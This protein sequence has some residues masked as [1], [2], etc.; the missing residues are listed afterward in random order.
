MRP[1]Y[2]TLG[3]G[4]EVNLAGQV[5]KIKV[6]QAS[7]PVLFKTP[8]ETAPADLGETITF[9]KATNGL[10]VINTHDASNTLEMIVI[11]S[12]EGALEA[13]ASAVSIANEPTVIIGGAVSVAGLPQ[14][15]VAAGINTLAANENRRT[16]MIH[17]GQNNAGRV[18]IGGTSEN[19]GI[20][21]DADD[22][23][24]LNTRGAVSIWATNA[25]DTVNALE[26]V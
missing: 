7:G 21:L 20:P 11:S 24:E 4:Q 2:L 6:R 19:V 17:A 8:D 22:T 5:K 15:V 3:Q 23:I 10:Q 9:E 1:V 13:A 14:I 26:V 16:L 12:D 18:W 25:G